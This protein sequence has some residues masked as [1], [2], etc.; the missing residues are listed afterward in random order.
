MKYRELGK[1]GE[2][3][4]TIGLG[5]M[6]M[7][8]GYGVANDDESIATLHL[9]LDLGINFWDTADIYADG[10]NEELVSKVLRPNRDKVFIATKF[11]FRKADA[12]AMPGQPGSFFDGSPAY[13][14]TAVEKSLKRLNIEVIDLYYAHRV[15]PKVPVEEMVGAMAE[16]VKEGKVRYLGLSEAG[17]ASLRKA[18]AVHPIAALQS[19][20]SLLTRD[21]EAEILPVCRE[22]GISLVPFSP[23]SRGLIT[24]TLK[25]DSLREG[26]FRKTLPRFSDAYKGNN[27]NLA[28][29]FAGFAEQKGCTAAQLA[30][31]WVLAQGDDIIPIPGTKRT[32]YLRENAASVDIELTDADLAAIN[33][34]VK[35]HGNIGPRYSE[36]AMKLVN[37]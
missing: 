9:A 2:K 21:L 34:I 11:G 35:Q 24:N 3:L 6:G 8:H 12:N 16:L 36:G 20:Y 1:T 32:K 30:L 25:V 27:E 31:A 23:L 19:E 28:A 15:D 29:A 14:R 18:Q 5:C 13:M 26:D 10:K 33:E 4:S 37:N 22:L 7:N 17:A